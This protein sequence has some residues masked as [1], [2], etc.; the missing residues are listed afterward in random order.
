MTNSDTPPPGAFVLPEYCKKAEEASPEL[1]RQL[2][3]GTPM[4][5]M[6]RGGRML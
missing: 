6:R 4:A 3:R 2:V 5:L 1:A